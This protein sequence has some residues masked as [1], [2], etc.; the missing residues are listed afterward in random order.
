MA[1]G[2]S[3][4][5]F[6]SAWEKLGR[7]FPLVRLPF[8]TQTDWDRLLL[9][10]DFL[11]VRGEDSLSRAVLSGLPFLWQAY[12]QA[13]KQQLVKV[14]ALL[15]RM[16][17]CFN[18]E[19][20]VLWQAASIALND[21]LSDSPSTSGREKILPLLELAADSKA[22]LSPAFSSFSEE[23]LA[24]GNLALPLLTLLRDFV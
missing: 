6:I 15:E 22:A 1:A 5:C 10:S 13:E 18:P 4:A 12:P 16:R 14:E 8:L 19:D 11:I 17:H 9:D 24:L 2:K 21:R 3:S 23:V 20:F 7:P